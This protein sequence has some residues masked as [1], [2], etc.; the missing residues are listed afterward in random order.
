MQEKGASPALDAA[1]RLCKSMRMDSVTDKKTLR[2]Q[3]MRLRA[4]IPDEQRAEIDAGIAARVL[5]LPAYRTADAVFTYLDMGAEIRTRDIIADAWAA[6][7]TVAL[8]RCIPGTRLMAWHRVTS[9][10]G[11]VASRFGVAEPVD[12]PETLVRPADFAAPIALVPG[13][14]FDERGY[15]IG[16]GGGFYDVFLASF[17]GKTVGL[18]RESLLVERLPF[19]G[20]HDLPVQAVATERRVVFAS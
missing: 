9:L 18:C 4:G 14:A 5:A 3:L 13:L 8:P 2:A 12:D 1:S 10:D 16:Y 6:G 17:P 11:L 20:A 7:K 19:L 15:R